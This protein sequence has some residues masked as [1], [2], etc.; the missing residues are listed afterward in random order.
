MYF[1]RV[2]KDTVRKRRTQLHTVR[3]VNFE[4]LNL[5]G[6]ESYDNFVD[7]IFKA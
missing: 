4:G 7:Y 6:L 3:V 2:I 5:C 1:R